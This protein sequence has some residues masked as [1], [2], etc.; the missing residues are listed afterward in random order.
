MIGGFLVATL[1][2][3]V[4]VGVIGSSNLLRGE[5]NQY[6]TVAIPGTKVL[7]LPEG[8]A[9]V[10][11]AI[12]LP[13]RGN[14]T[15]DLPLPS[16]LSVAISPV[17]G[18]ERPTVHRDVA[19]SSNA[20]ADGVDTKRQVWTVDVPSDGDYRVTTKGNFRSIGVNPQLWLGHGPPLPGTLVPVVA[21]GLVLLGGL[22][23]FAFSRIR[24]RRPSVGPPTGA[25]VAVTFDGSPA[26]DH[27]EALERLA[28]LRDR[29]ALTEAEFE[30]EKAKI[31]G[32]G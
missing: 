32:D 3:C 26:A 8:T 18:S 17:G 6:G 21:A 30:T 5:P 4:P 15:P 7:H 2:L 20:S 25:P 12:A 11:V 24:R 9:D 16:D 23:W 10:S 1:V 13:G 14:E 22:I 31:L 19:S 27:T 28:D 29:G